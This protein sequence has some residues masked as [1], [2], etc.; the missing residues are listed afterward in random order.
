MACQVR[1]WTFT[2]FNNTGA[3]D[4]SRISWNTRRP[5]IAY[6]TCQLEKCP[7]TGTIHYQGYLECQRASGR[8][9]VKKAIGSKEV[10]LE[11][12]KGTQTQAIAYCKKEESRTELDGIPTQ[13]EYGTKTPDSPRKGG[14]AVYGLALHAENYATAINIIQEGAPRDYVLWN[15]KITSTLHKH[16]KA[17]Y[18]KPDLHFNRETIPDELITKRPII[19]SGGTGLGKTQY[20]LH[21]FNYPLICSHIDDLKKMTPDHDGIIFDDMS[22]RHWPATACIHIVDMEL[23]RS[24]NVKHTTVTI[25]AFT[26]RIFTT[27]RDAREL[28]S[29]LA[30]EDEWNAILRRI[31]IIYVESSLFDINE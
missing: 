28:F 26:K 29:E 8:D 20:A 17:D 22:F 18:K 24:V 11:P 19:L 25:P 2:L 13:F 7:T 5:K 31:E 30:N 1:F 9:S 14:D 4:P 27:N 15:D 16:F 6:L 23:P 10:H 12:R 21:H 3:W